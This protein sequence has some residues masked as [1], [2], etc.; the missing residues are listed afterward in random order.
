MIFCLGYLF[1]QCLN[2]MYLNCRDPLMCNFL[3]LLL[4]NEISTTELHDHPW[5]VESIDMEL[6]IWKVNCRGIHSFWLHRGWVPLILLLF[7]GQLMHV[8]I[9]ILL[10]IVFIS[11]SNLRKQPL[12]GK[13]L[14]FYQ[15]KKCGGQSHGDPMV[16]TL[17]SLLRVWV[18]P[19]VGKLRSHPTSCMAKQKTKQNRKK[20]KKKKGKK[21]TW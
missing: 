10:Y 8:Y 5:L 1:C 17:L 7:K 21:V 19:P 12:S 15:K 4:F 18:Q 20:K 14:G 3:F 6:W 16:R 9:C 2:N 11:V 13:W